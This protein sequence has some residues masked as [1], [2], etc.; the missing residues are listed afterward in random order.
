MMGKRTSAAK[1]LNKQPKGT[2]SPAN[3]IAVF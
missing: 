3:P 1:K 2:G